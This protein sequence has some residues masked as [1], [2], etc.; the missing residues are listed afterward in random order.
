MSLQNIHHFSFQMFAWSCLKNFTCFTARQP[1]WFWRPSI[2]GLYWFVAV[3]SNKGIVTMALGINEPMRMT[4]GGAVWNVTHLFKPLPSNSLLCGKVAINCFCH[5]HV[6][7]YLQTWAIPTQT[8]NSRTYTYFC[9]QNWPFIVEVQ[10]IKQLLCRVWPG[11]NDT[12]D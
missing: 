3:I 4:T 5:S 6:Q 2:A 10:R 12:V 8:K 7:K 1:R 11:L 9:T